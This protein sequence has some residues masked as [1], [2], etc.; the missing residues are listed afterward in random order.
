MEYNLE[1]GRAVEKI[2]EEKAKVVC[3]QLPDGLKPKAAEIQEEL[4]AKTGAQVI[5]WAGSNFGSCD[6][7]T[8]A[9]QLGVELLIA[10]GHS[11]WQW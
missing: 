9:K 10:W 8:E 11:E 1:L 7:P 4:E 2:R 3:I 6:F 5:I